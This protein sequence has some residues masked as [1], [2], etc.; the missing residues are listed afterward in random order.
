MNIVDI[1]K[2]VSVV[3]TFLI[4]TLIP[5]IIVLVKKAKQAKKAKTEAERQE[6][7]NE[8]LVQAQG[9]IVEAENLYAQ[10][11]SIVKQQGGTCGAI[12]KDGVMTKLQAVCLDKGIEFDT[13]FWSKTVDDLVLMTRQVNAK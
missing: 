4:G 5:T 6:I 8:M 13:E 9:F 7:I 10:V 12:K 1:L 3:A 2:I 11:N